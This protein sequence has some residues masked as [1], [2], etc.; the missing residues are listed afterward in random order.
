MIAAP[1]KPD[2]AIQ[3]KRLRTLRPEP[4]FNWL[5]RL[6][7]IAIALFTLLWIALGTTF[8]SRVAPFYDSLAYQQDY[9]LSAT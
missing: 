1:Y 3:Q 4:L 7:L 6:A 5:S 8:Y 9:I 2:L